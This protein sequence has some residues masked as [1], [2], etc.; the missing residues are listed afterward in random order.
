[1]IGLVILIYTC[2]FVGQMLY[3]IFRME[4]ALIFA[5]SKSILLA[6]ALSLI[7]GSSFLFCKNKKVST[8]ITYKDLVKKLKGE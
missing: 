5:S 2:C 7:P 4:N 1:M 3:W 6:I 8:G